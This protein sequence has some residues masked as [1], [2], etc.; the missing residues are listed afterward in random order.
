MS[1][2]TF[3]YFFIW[4]NAFIYIEYIFLNSIFISNLFQM[5]AILMNHSNV[6]AM[7]I[8]YRFSICAMVHQIVQM[9]TMKIRNYAQ[10]VSE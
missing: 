1:K 8:V 7:D 10:L 3:L 6:Q 5:L 2:D 4:S 9:P